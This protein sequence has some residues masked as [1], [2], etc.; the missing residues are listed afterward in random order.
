MRLFLFVS[1]FVARWFAAN[2]TI[3]IIIP[4]VRC[5]SLIGALCCWS[6]VVLFDRRYPSFRNFDSTISVD[7]VRIKSHMDSL[8]DPTCVP[9][10]VTINKLNFVPNRKMPHFI[11]VFWNCGV[12]LRTSKPYISAVFFYPFLHRSPCFPNIYFA[13]FTWNLTDNTVLLVGM[14]LIQFF[15][16]RFPAFFGAQQDEAYAAQ[17]PKDKDSIVVSIHGS[18]FFTF[19]NISRLHSSSNVVYSFTGHWRTKVILADNFYR[20]SKVG[21][22]DKAEI[23]KI[24]PFTQTLSGWSSY[25]LFQWPRK[26]WNRSERASSFPLRNSSW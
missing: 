8:L 2:G 5:C 1:L 9:V 15:R 4:T 14:Y 22:N 18:F 13:A 3:L 23:L 11:S 17:R 25:F 19:R 10:R 24:K 21:E 16:R 12:S 20:R 6:A 7:V 26:A